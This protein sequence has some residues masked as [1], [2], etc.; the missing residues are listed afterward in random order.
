MK[1]PNAPPANAPAM[2]AMLPPITAP[3][4]EVDIMEGTT[5][6]H[7]SPPH[8]LLVVVMEDCISSVVLVNDYI[9]YKN[10]DSGTRL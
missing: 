2:C 1:M 4:M 7:F 9:C 6:L 10:R 8:C 5:E 3:P